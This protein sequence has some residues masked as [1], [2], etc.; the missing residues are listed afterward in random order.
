ML[1]SSCATPYRSVSPMAG[2]ICTNLQATMGT[3][4]YFGPTVRR[5]IIHG[6]GSGVAFLHSAG[7]SSRAQTVASAHNWPASRSFIK[8][9]VAAIAGGYALP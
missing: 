1:A 5:G 4:A 2:S 6:S 3:I 9:K 8:A 7:N